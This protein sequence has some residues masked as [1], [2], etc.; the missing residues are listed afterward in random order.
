MTETATANRNDAATS[1]QPPKP[2]AG[3]Q[4]LN[5]FVGKW[6]TEG[7][8]YEGPVGPAARTSAVETYEWLTGEFFLIHRFQGRVGDSE[9]ACIEVIGHDAQSQTYPIHTFYNNGLAQRW[10]SR[11]NDGT[12]T[13]TGDWD[14]K[15][16]TMRVRLTT[17]FS[18]GGRTMKGKWECSKDGSSW[19][20][21]WDVTARRAS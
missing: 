19:Q 5:A 18:D 13:L 4:R 14:L 7:E 11:E 17:V 1:Q 8:Q 10:E 20:A 15:G 3:H 12:W 2:G 9:A 16:Q 21:F 6:N